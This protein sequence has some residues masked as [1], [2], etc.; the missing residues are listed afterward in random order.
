[1]GE[2]FRNEDNGNWYLS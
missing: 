2:K 1:M